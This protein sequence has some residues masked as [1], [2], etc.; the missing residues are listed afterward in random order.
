MPGPATK[1]SAHRVLVKRLKET[2]RERGRVLAG[3]AIENLTD[4]SMVPTAGIMQNE[5]CS[6]HLPVDAHI[7]RIASD[8][9]KLIDGSSPSP[10]P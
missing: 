7:A 2:P 9:A 1:L 8:N 3:Q 6:S 5:Q 10:H 4:H